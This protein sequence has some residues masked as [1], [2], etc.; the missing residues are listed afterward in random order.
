[1][2]N[3]VSDK[4]WSMFPDKPDVLENAKNATSHGLSQFFRRNIEGFGR[5]V[6]IG[7][8]FNSA[9]K[10][11]KVTFPDKKPGYHYIIEVGGDADDWDIDPEYTLEPFKRSFVGFRIV[12]NS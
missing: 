1:M 6:I 7:D 12:R 5:R 9:T 3:P 10:S 11:R 2:K 8:W 4:D